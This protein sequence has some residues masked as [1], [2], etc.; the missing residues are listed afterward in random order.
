M[1]SP[2]HASIS[3]LHAL[4]LPCTRHGRAPWECGGL[5]GAHG[6]SRSDIIQA[7]PSEIREPVPVRLFFLL[8][9]GSGG[10]RDRTVPLRSFSVRKPLLGRTRRTLPL[11]C[12]PG[13][14]S[15]CI[16]LNFIT[17]RLLLF[18]LPFLKT[19]PQLSKQKCVFRGP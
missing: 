7:I 12:F 13:D 1:P 15:F 5:D 19:A 9:S 2:L 11:F 4:T 18:L 8:L 16:G 17:F 6:I 10:G 3:L 14:T